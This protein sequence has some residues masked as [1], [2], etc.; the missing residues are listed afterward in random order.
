M[1]G[2]HI[3]LT[4]TILTTALLTS[5]VNGRVAF[6]QTS[7][8]AGT[9]QPYTQSLS[10]QQANYTILH[11]HPLM[12]DDVYG[13]GNRQQPFKTITQALTAAQPGTVIVLAPGR[14]TAETGETFPLRLKPGVTLQGNPNTGQSAIIM[15]GGHFQSATLSQQNATILTSDH[16][17]LGYVVVSNP[18]HQGHG[19]WVEA[20]HPVIRNS[21]FVANRHTGVYVAGGSPSIEGSYFAQN[22]VAGLVLYGH[23]RASIRSNHFEDTGTAI[24]IAAGAVPEIVSNRII[25]NNEGIVLLGNASPTLANND[26]SENRRNGVVEV[27]NTPPPIQLAASTEITSLQLTVALDGVSHPQPLARQELASEGA[28]AITPELVRTGTGTDAAVPEAVRADATAP[29]VRAEATV[30]ASVEPERPSTIAVRPEPESRVSI[31][32]LRSQQTPQSALPETRETETRE[33]E[34]VTPSA[35]PES[36][37]TASAAPQSPATADLAS[38]PTLPTAVSRLETPQIS[39][40]SASPTV[41]APDEEP[42]VPNQS[43]ASTR[44]DATTEELPRRVS[45]A[46][47]RNRLLSRAPTEATAPTVTT[48]ATASPDPEAIPIAVIPAVTTSSVATPVPATGS[49]ETSVPLPNVPTLSIGADHRLP[50]PSARIPVGGGGRAIAT[51]SLPSASA[52][53]GPPAP[54]SRAAALGLHYRVFVEAPDEYAQQRLRELVPDAFRTQLNGRHLMQAGAFP[55]EATAQERLQLLLD[56]GLDAR[57]EYLP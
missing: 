42:A 24:T 45:I 9:Q 49:S 29:P 40:S 20:G 10:S 56:R 27:G 51:T 23:S 14:Y 32:A 6:A 53:G 26:I 11:V 18:H 44:V 4:V 43:P 21:A 38:L 55:D 22:R 37:P 52:N 36:T 12:G 31:Q 25:R 3:S 8:Y 41:N 13:T 46:D 7:P 47:L 28:D 57:M 17:G 19:V 5:G 2:K 15:G 48:A 1:V 30:P 16:S 54:P 39:P 50:V 33:T 34:I 35:T